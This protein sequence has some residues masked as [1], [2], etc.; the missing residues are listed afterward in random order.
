MSFTNKWLR[1]F[2]MGS[3]VSSVTLPIRCGRPGTAGLRPA[4]ERRG[5][6][7]VSV[8]VLVRPSLFYEM[9]S[10]TR[11]FLSLRNARTHSEL[12]SHRR[13]YPE[14]CV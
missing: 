7:A 13:T 12:N 9:N 3:L 5:L 1:D 6:A 8:D 2:R 4:M 14:F 10:Q 11:L